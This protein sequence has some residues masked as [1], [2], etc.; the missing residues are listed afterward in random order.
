[1][2]RLYVQS[3]VVHKPSIKLREITRDELRAIFNDNWNWKKLKLTDNYYYLPEKWEDWDKVFQYLMPKLPTYKP[4]KVDCENFGQFISV[5]AAIELDVT[6]CGNAEGYA[7][8]Q[9]LGMKRHGWTVFPHGK[10]LFQVES[11]LKSG[12]T[13]MDIDNPLYVPDEIVV[14]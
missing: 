6:V 13:L 1:M 2:S 11:Q 4:D 7:N 8:V 9:G 14:G 5:M 10:Y 12:Y 3:P